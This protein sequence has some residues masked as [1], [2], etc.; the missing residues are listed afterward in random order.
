MTATTGT[1]P[2]YEEGDDSAANGTT[3]PDEVRTAL[4]KLDEG[5]LNE[6]IIKTDSVWYVV[7]L[8][9]KN[10]KT[11][12]ESKKESLTNTKK[13]DF[14][15]D[16]TD[17][18]K[19][20]ADIKEEKKLIKKIKITDNHSFTIQTPTPTPDPDVTETPTAD[21]AEAEATETPETEGDSAKADEETADSTESEAAAT[22]EAEK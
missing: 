18:W 22:P 3:Y 2:T 20:K 16:T 8:D 9:S 14:Y 17:G 13:D 15:N 7:R 6:E 1:C 21:S 19:K 12:T 11:A 4:R 10:D 5:A